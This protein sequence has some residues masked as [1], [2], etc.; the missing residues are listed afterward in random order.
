MDASTKGVILVTGA[1]A[2]IG[3]ACAER[4]HGAG[5]S[6]FG[7]AR[8]SV[9]DPGW[10][11]LVMDVDDDASVAS[12]VETIL[13]QKGRLDGVVACAGWGLA[14]ATEHTPIT[15]AKAQM[16]TNFWGAVR[17]VQQALPA[18]R[19]RGAG[20]IVLISSLG[21]IIGIPFQSFY[22]ASKFAMEGY[23]EA[24]AYE[25]APF[26]IQVTMVEPGNIKTDFTSSRRDVEPPA[27]DPYRAAVAKAIGTMIE[28]ER[29]GAPP[30]DVARAV[31]RVLEA[32][33]PPRRV[34]VGKFDERIGLMGKRLLPYR[35]FERAAKGSLGV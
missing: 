30:D 15:A 35:L 27:D 7:A 32:R 22:S 19:S 1:S 26:G 11:S 20:R 2:G 12:G 16:E 14:G 17:V 10:T 3:L 31:Q 29:N 4:L 9:A 23:G 8:R 21:G 5:W 28:D 18:M 34:S 13:S 24:L 25:V 33:R 6:V